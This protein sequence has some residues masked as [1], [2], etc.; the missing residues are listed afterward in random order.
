MH[1]AFLWAWWLGLRM[2]AE[3]W[4]QRPKEPRAEEDD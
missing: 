1:L 4:T 3:G 2:T